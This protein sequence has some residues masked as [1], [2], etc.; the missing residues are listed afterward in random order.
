MTLSFWYRTA[1]PSVVVE[2]GQRF[3]DGGAAPVMGIGQ[4]G[5]PQALA[6][7]RRSVVL[8]L[9]ALAGRSV[10]P[11]AST[12]LRFVITGSA[13]ASLDI[14]EVQLEE[15]AVGTPFER[16]SPARELLLARR[17][18]RRSAVA[19]PAADLAVEMATPPSVSGTGPFD[20]AA[21]I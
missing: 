4:A 13:A 6:W 14:A 12:L 2:A 17:F 18:F 20:Y 3:G 15:G 9:P 1:S 19:L 16:R 11:G 10:G 8:A 21:E 7:T 5:L